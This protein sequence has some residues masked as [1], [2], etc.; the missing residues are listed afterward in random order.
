MGAKAYKTRARPSPLVGKKKT[1]ECKPHTVPAGADAIGIHMGGTLDHNTTTDEASIRPAGWGGGG[2][3]ILK[4]SGRG[5]SR[6]LLT[7]GT[8]R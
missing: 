3:D 1:K 4:L 6:D 7:S 8:L 5:R 2:G